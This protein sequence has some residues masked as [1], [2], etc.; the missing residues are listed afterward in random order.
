MQRA[1]IG[2]DI[3]SLLARKNLEYKN[4]LNKAKIS[5]P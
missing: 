2:M 5:A 1:A 3:E 4:E